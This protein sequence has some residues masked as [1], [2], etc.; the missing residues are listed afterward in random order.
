M[1]YEASQ[2]AKRIYREAV[3]KGAPAEE[4]EELK[5]KYEQLE[6]QENL[7][8]VSGFA[9]PKLAAFSK[10]DS[11][12][13]LDLYTWGLIPHWVKDEDQAFKLWNQTLN[14]RGETVFEKPSFR[15]AIQNSRV[16]IPLDGFFEYHHKAGKTYPYFIRRKDG[17]M[18]QTA[19]I[20]SEWLNRNTGELI[21]SLAI[22]TV[23]GNRLMSEIHNSPKLAGPR[24]PL[25]LTDEESERWLEADLE[26]VRELIRPV[27]HEYLEA[28]T[29]RPLRGKN[30]V[31]NVPTVQDEFVYDE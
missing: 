1:C 31:G 18:L 7:Y 10:K 19:G 15:D 13:E 29:V 28:H 20:A 9:H 16:I 25:F 12:L 8:H 2:L 4:L 22:V 24:M 14:A 3:R 27:E 30:Y 17:E 26:Q 5:K 11:K 23:A 21:K 6:Q